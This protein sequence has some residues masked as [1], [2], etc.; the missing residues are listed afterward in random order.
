MT[1]GITG[2]A[3]LA[4]QRDPPE[5]AKLRHPGIKAS[6]E[7]IRKSLMGDYRSEYLLVLRQSYG[8]LQGRDTFQIY[9][10]VFQF[11]GA[12]VRMD[13]P[14]LANDLCLSSSARPSQSELLGSG[15]FHF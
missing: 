5:L 6:G 2:L 9:P 14:L 7:T 12:G 13:I 8:Q 3:I 4:G 1:S 10:I 15:D 11:F